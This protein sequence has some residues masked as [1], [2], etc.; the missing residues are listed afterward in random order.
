MSVNGKFRDIRLQ[1]FL[2]V[3]DRFLVPRHRELIRE[4][5]AAIERWP[6]FAAAAGLPRGLARSIRSDFP[7]FSA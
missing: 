1:D 2:V 6:E 7:A 4:V 3:A 5:V